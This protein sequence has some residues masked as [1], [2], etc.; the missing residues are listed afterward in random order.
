MRLVP[1]TKTFE[2][3]WRGR[4]FAQELRWDQVGV[5]DL[6]GYGILTRGECGS[7][8]FQAKKPLSSMTLRP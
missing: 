8:A 3:R 5:F 6:D 2:A 4:N 7:V 1:G